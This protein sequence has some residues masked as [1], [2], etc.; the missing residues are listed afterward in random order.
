MRNTRHDVD[1]KTSGLMAFAAELANL[2]PDRRPFTD[3]TWL[4]PEPA[5]PPDYV[6]GRAREILHGIAIRR[7]P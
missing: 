1:E 4:I 7:Q 3:L 2:V 5:T 6:A